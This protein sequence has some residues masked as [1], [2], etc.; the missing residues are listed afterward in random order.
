MLPQSLP[1]ITVSGRCLHRHFPKTLSFFFLSFLN[2]TNILPYFFN[3][4]SALNKLV[5]IKIN[6]LFFCRN[7]TSPLIVFDLMGLVHVLKTNPT[8]ALFAGRHQMLIALYEKFFFH[9]QSL[10]AT[11]AFFTDGTVQNEKIPEWIKRQ[12]SKYEVQI[13]FYDKHDTSR[14]PAVTTITKSLIET[15]KRIG[16]F[17]YSI[18]NDCDKEVARYATENNAL[19]VIAGDTDFLIFKGNWNYWSTYHLDFDQLKTVEFSRSTLRNHL[20]LNVKQ[21]AIFGTICGNDIVSQRLLKK[22]TFDS[23][24]KKIMYISKYVRSITKSSST[25]T[26]KD[27]KAISLA[28]FE[29]DDNTNVELIKTSI[30]FYDINSFND[31]CKQSRKLALH[32]GYLYNILIDQPNLISLNYIDFRCCEAEVF[33]ENIKVLVKRQM[34]I[35]LK[36]KQNTALTRRVFIKCSHAQPPS[37]YILHAQ[38]PREGINFII[39]QV[40]TF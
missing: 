16:Y 38:Y 23:L 2:L 7:K 11:L 32:L 26:A 24:E 37:E 33:A 22:L 6:H 40:A 4:Y 27:L 39:I 12:S 10:G 36:H 14:I 5:S 15:C 1:S 30:D 19:A 17:H 3:F 21:M 29:R 28:F 34:G 8:D 35:L 31:T 13:Q 25:L 9:L 20:K 18:N